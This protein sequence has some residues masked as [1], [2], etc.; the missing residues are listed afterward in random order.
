[1][2]SEY[3]FYLTAFI[4]DIDKADRFQEADDPFP[5][6]YRVDRLE[7]V[8]LLWLSWAAAPL[9]LADWV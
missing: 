6:I 1:M 9:P 7:D 3:Y 4:E 8:A 2:F 5:T